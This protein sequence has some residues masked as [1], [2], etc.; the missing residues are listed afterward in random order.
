MDT[1]ESLSLV[2]ESMDALRVVQQCFPTK[3][4]QK[5]VRMAEHLIRMCQRNKLE[6]VETLRR[7]TQGILESTEYSVSASGQT[8]SQALVSQTS[9]TANLLSAPFEIDQVELDSLDW[10]N[11]LRSD[12]AFDLGFSDS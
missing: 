9:P 12:F 1:T 8:Y 4:V 5:A 7:S 6:A 2:E 10:E 11:F 3:T